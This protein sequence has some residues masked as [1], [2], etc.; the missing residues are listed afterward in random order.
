MGY[1]GAVYP[2]AF[3]HRLPVAGRT[4]RRFEDGIAG[5]FL[6]STDFFAAARTEG[7]RIRYMALFDP[8]R[9]AACRNPFAKLDTE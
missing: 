2:S 5:S 9:P 6:M 1:L 8:D 4:I 3:I 7:S